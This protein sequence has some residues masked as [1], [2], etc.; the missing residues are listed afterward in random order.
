MAPREIKAR[1]RAEMVGD[2]PIEGRLPN[3]YFRATE[4]SN[5]AWLVEGCDIWGRMVS[6]AGG[7]PEELLSA[8][9]N[10]AAQILS[11]SSG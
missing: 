5:N 10:D 1:S 7:D 4:T 8:C 3:W 11:P 2:Y 6:R 9:V